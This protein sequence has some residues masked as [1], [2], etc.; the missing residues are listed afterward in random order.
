MFHHVAKAG[1]LRTAFRASYTLHRPLAYQT[2]QFCSDVPKPGQRPLE[3]LPLPEGL[4]GDKFE[5]YELL[6]TEGTDGGKGLTSVFAVHGP[7]ET[8]S[9]QEDPLHG[10]NGGCYAVME[11][12]GRQH[13][14]VADNALYLNR[15]D[16]DVNE[17]VVFDKVLLVGSIAWSVFG[18]PYIP[19]AK[20]LA[21][22][23]EQTL[24]GKVIVAKFK[25]RKGY[26]RRQG[27]RQNVT[28]VRINEVVFD[29]P[30]VDGMKPLEI[31]LDPFRPP[32]SNH[33]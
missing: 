7:P 5:L 2:R 29:M 31:A 20:V 33:S 16:G 3:I 13:K 8:W 4:S 23:E 11:A 18:R 15:I 10:A 26:R 14:V 19:T 21:T 32:L 28:R 22:I 9:Y 25:K 24:S 27:H 17:Q 30:T 1:V 12:G 6:G